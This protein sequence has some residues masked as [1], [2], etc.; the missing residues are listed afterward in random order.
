MRMFAAK[1]LLAKIAK[2]EFH[3]ISFEIM[4]T[5]PADNTPPTIKCSLYVHGFPRWFYGAT[6]KAAFIDMMGANFV[7]EA[8]LDDKL[9]DLQEPLERPEEIIRERNKCN[10]SMNAPQQEAA[11]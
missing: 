6:W 8:V 1:Q 5:S 7:N 2:G 3:S 10:N 4:H 11:L 9:E